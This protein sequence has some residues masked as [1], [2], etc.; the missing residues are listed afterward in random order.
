MTT[1]SWTPEERFLSAPQRTRKLCLRAKS[2]SSSLNSLEKTRLDFMCPM[3]MLPWLPTAS[4]SFLTVPLYC[5]SPGSI[6]LRVPCP[7]QGYE[8]R[9]GKG[10]ALP[11]KGGQQGR[12]WPPSENPCPLTALRAFCT[13]H[14]KSPLSWVW[15]YSFKPLNQPWLVF[16]PVVSGPRLGA[17]LA[18]IP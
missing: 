9:G 17:W 5:S 4:N 13:K 8:L 1:G 14:S 7:K 10:Q 11:G 16:K 6:F 2:T 12:S 18:P 3:H 15:P